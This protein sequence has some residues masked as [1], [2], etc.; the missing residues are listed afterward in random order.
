MR[1]FGP[2]QLGAP[3]P[4]RHSPTSALARV[5]SRRCRPFIAAAAVVVLL[6]TAVPAA[7]AN[8]APAKPSRPVVEAVAHDS[9]TIS[10]DDP[11]DASITGYQIL[12]RDRAVHAK[13]VFVVIEDD[14]ATT[15][16][17]YTDTT[18]DA[19]T[20]YVYRVIARNEHGTSPR[21]R[22][23]RVDVPDAPP[24]PEP[25][26]PTV[27]SDPE[28][29]VMPLDETT[30][31]LETLRQSH[32]PT[33]DV[34]GAPES[35]SV[36]PGYEILNVR[37]DAPS[38][39][40]GYPESDLTYSVRY[41]RYW[42]E[43]W[44]T[45]A[46]DLAG[47]S[48]IIRNLS[49]GFNYEIE[50]AAKNAAGTGDSVTVTGSPEAYGPGTPSIDSVTPGYDTLWVTWSQP[51]YLGG[52]YFSQI[53][54]T[55]QYRMG[56]TDDNWTT[57]ADDVVMSTFYELKSKITGLENGVEYD[58]RVGARTPAAA[59]P[60][61]VPSSATTT[62]TA[63]TSPRNAKVIPGNGWL[64]VEWQPPSN[65][66]GFL[67]SQL[68]YQVQY[69]AGSTG[70]WTTLTPSNI[71]GA[72]FPLPWGSILRYKA[73]TI[74]GLDNAVAHQVRIAASN[75]SGTS[76]YTSASGTPTAAEPSCLP[77]GAV[78]AG[79]VTVGDDPAGGFVSTL[80]DG[81]WYPTRTYMSVTLAAN[82]TYR[83]DMRRSPSWYGS[84][85]PRKVWGVYDPAGK[86][87][88]GTFNLSGRGTSHSYE[89]RVVFTA[90]TAGEYCVG[91]ATSSDRGGAYGM[92]ANALTTPTDDLPTG[93]NGTLTVGASAVT[94]T[95]NYLRDVDTFNVTL[96]AGKTYKFS[97]TDNCN[98]PTGF[99]T[100]TEIVSILDPDGNL[101]EEAP[102][103]YRQPIISSR[104]AV[105]TAQKS[106]DYQVS[107][108][109]GWK[110][111]ANFTLKAT[112]I[113]P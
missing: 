113:T 20:R 29:T 49:N 71:T 90:L 1:I 85:S 81:V 39:T 62:G 38:D 22:W 36:T 34:P 105:I 92:D 98:N 9:V 25:A 111:H 57:F 79:Q 51:R 97:V 68:T 32:E 80:V 73:A 4:Q 18:V 43:S 41:R 63:P 48:A 103:G 35:L 52:Y 102:E 65:T 87:V 86:L 91:V 75:A 69:R 10:W 31:E 72:A 56:G 21:S 45:F 5:P 14:T 110:Y 83:I 74:P 30:A 89:G 54:Y 58:V 88:P 61:S 24:Q 78:R 112:E 67:Y 50:V 46:A 55:V 47:E 96:V 16:T 33:G 76:N 94:V 27:V 7:A 42:Y 12:R 8:G 99:C 104:S 109:E 3:V 64:R 2:Q 37:W 13:G 28:D 11:G 15:A 66:G 6:M 44:K 77:A 70:D 101:V 95:M 60:F 93:T 19:S 59:G 23:Q 26:A 108:G 107:V 84:V 100:L 106:G 40:G 82:T 53:V 17:S